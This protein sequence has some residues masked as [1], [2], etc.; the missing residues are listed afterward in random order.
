ML[1]TQQITEILQNT[2]DDDWPDVIAKLTVDI[3]D[4]NNFSFEEAE[5]LIDEA[6]KYV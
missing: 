5:K 1:D 2:V 6:M 4:E 3:A